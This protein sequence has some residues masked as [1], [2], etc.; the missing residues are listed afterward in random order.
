MHH[1]SI[2]KD[3]YTTTGGCEKKSTG[4]ETERTR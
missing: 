1:L 3:V 2:V 4:T